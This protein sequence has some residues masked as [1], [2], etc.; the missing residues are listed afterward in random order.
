MTVINTNIS[1]LLA[2]VSLN[3]ARAGAETAMERLSSGQR[4]NSAAD[5]AAGLSI[6]SRM[7][8]QITGIRA[9]IKNANDGISLMDTAEGAMAEVTNM[10]QRM[11]ELALQSANDTNSVNDRDASQSEIDA[12][13]TE[14]DRVASTTTF[15][16]LNI[17]DGG[18]TGGT[19]AFALQVG[20]STDA[21]ATITITIGGLAAADLNT[22]AGGGDG[23]EAT[24]LEMDTNAHAS[25]AIDNIDDA[26]EYVNQQRSALGAV[27]NRLDH[28]ISNLTSISTNTASAVDIP[29]STMMALASVIRGDAP[30]ANADTLRR[31][32]QAATADLPPDSSQ[33][34]IAAPSASVM[35]GASDQITNQRRSS[36]G[37][38]M[39]TRSFENAITCRRFRRSYGAKPLRCTIRNSGGAAIRGFSW[40]SRARRSL[41]SDWRSS[42]M[43]RISVSRA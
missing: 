41:A 17:L 3:A 31:C 23:V 40:F 6:A 21:D 36:E 28:T 10:L 27:R 11:R 39:A 14:I 13:S 33:A 30:G 5:D 2:Q 37:R 38:L 35:R 16:G 7:T 42:L 8:A 26:I 15:N 34:Q 1:S 12:L 18:G 24:D 20:S 32:N 9:A 43:T 19:R 4:I 22:V 29:A 25:T